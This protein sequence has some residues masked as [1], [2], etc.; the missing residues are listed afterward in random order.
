MIHLESSRKLLAEL[1]YN[2]TQ[3]T[4]P[5]GRFSPTTDPAPIGAAVPEL[6]ISLTT[7]DGIIAYL[8]VQAAAIEKGGLFEDA[9]ILLASEVFNTWRYY[10]APTWHSDA[11]L[12]D[13]PQ[14]TWDEHL[15]RANKA[16]ESLTN[17][18][19]YHSQQNSHLV[20]R[21]KTTD[22][23][24]TA[25]LL[26][27]SERPFLATF[28]ELTKLVRDYE[29]ARS[30]SSSWSSA[31]PL[32][33]LNLALT[34]IILRLLFQN[35][36]IVP[37]PAQRE[38]RREG[39]FAA[40]LDLAETIIR[41]KDDPPDGGLPRPRP[42]VLKSLSMVAHIGSTQA[43]RRRGVALMRDYPQRN[44]L[45]DSIM[46]AR[47]HEVLLDRE[48]ELLR[49][50]RGEADG[51]NEDREDEEVPPLDRA[52]NAPLTFVG[53]RSAVMSNRTWNEMMRGETGETKV[54]HW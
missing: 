32:Q 28:R 30:L 22:D 49:R 15:V 3:K 26:D 37:D 36:P 53:E 1:S 46:Q 39:H 54:V 4:R 29:R 10:Q 17:G 48:Q 7:A 40:I 52:F 14:A 31:P 12:I 13:T 11:E 9:D 24:E 18:M 43:L 42:L 33:M 5:E 34:M 8:E 35:D 19:V 50:A 16:A 6:P 2:M 20:H 45:L 21:V 51:S 25:N 27:I 23:P 38:Q 47:V 44:G 41:R